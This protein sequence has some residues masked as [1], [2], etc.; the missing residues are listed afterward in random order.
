MWAHGSLKGLERLDVFRSDI[1]GLNRRWLSLMGTA[2]RSVNDT[3]KKSFGVTS[4][5]VNACAQLKMS[6][7]LL[8]NAARLGV[9]AF[10]LSEVDEFAKA[11]EAVRR[12]QPLPEPPSEVDDVTDRELVAE[13]RAIG[14]AYLSLIRNALW[15]DPV[16]A[17]AMFGLDQRLLELRHCSLG[18]MELLASSPACVLGPR[19]AT[20]LEAQV[21]VQNMEKVRTDQ[22][23]A[24]RNWCLLASDT[25]APVQP[26]GIAKAA[27]ANDLY[28]TIMAISG[29]TA[30]GL[31]A[32]AITELTGARKPLIRTAM[33]AA[34]RSNNDRG[35]RRYSRVP[36]LIEVPRAH[37]AASFFLLNYLKANKAYGNQSDSVCPEAFVAAYAI[38]RSARRTVQINPEVALFV[39]EVYHRGDIHMTHHAFCGSAFIELA[40][41]VALR[42]GIFTKGECPVCRLSE[43]RSEAA[44]SRSRR[45]MRGQFL[46]GVLGGMDG[47]RNPARRSG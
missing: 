20:A 12:K 6:D 21:R 3:L 19:H 7:E 2:S 43:S 39:A 13:Y 23:D 37:S 11:L 47:E 17:C 15:A 30:T 1:E 8:S 45:V 27:M 36:S 32:R 40:D 44:A 22:L 14:Y 46:K 28:H 24:I 9:P 29:L 25:N 41:P 26:E 10:H 38:S 35:G 33:E 5:L 31:T 16:L 42:R 18:D 34:G 4:N